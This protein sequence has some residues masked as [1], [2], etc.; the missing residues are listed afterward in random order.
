MFQILGYLSKYTTN[1]ELQICIFLFI[2]C[3]F[4][5]TVRKDCFVIFQENHSTAK[6]TQVSMTGTKNRKGIF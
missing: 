6:S 3:L 5:E 1:V 2:G 4:F